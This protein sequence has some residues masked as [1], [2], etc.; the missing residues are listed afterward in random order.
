MSIAAIGLLLLSSVGCGGPPPMADLSPPPRVVAPMEAPVMPVDPLR[1]GYVE[2]GPFPEY[3]V[4]PGDELELMLR[5][6][7]LVRETVE[8]RPDGNISFLLVE[9]LYVTGMTIGELD[10]A[11]TAAVE[12]YFREPKIDVQVSE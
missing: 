11:L 7:E 9:N 12:R 6:V 2:R 3:T 10:F 5:D 4:G 8:V 1:R